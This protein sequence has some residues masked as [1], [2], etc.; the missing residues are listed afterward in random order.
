LIHQQQSRMN[1]KIK[2]QI[3]PLHQVK[4]NE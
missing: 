3:H 4:R 2:Q 1:R